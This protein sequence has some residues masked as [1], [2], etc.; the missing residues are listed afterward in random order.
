M[1]EKQPPKNKSR[2]HS[3][4]LPAQKYQ[5][6]N[7]NDTELRPWTIKLPEPPPLWS[8]DGYGLAPEEQYFQYTEDPPRLKQLSLSAYEQAN[9]KYDGK[10]VLYMQMKLFWKMLSDEQESYQEEIALIRRVQW[11]IRYG[12][13]FFLQGRPTW[14]T[15]WHYYY[16]NFYYPNTLR[17]RRVDYRD[18]D[19]ITELFEWYC[20]TCTEV[21]KELDEKGNAVPNE[22]GEY[23]MIDVGRRVCFGSIQPKR[24]RKG[25]TMKANSKM[26]QCTTL[27]REFHSV[28]QANTG[29]AAEDLY[30][31]HVLPA[32]KKLPI[33]LR[34][35]YDGALDSSAGIYFR[36]PGSIGH[37]N[38][39]DSW[40]VWNPSAKEGVNDRRKIAWLVDDEAAKV[41]TADVSK[42]WAIDKLTLAQ[43]TSIHG[44]SVHPSTVEEMSSSGIYYQTMWEHSNF[45]KRIRANGQTLSG[46]FRI[47]RKVDYGSDGFI[48][49][50]GYSVVGDPTEWQLNNPAHDSVY[51]ILKKGSA[52]YWDEYYADMIADSTKHSQYRIEIR[53]NP[54]RSA[55][56]WL[57]SVGDMGW[58]YIILDQRLAELRIKPVSIKGNFKRRGDIVD[59]HQDDNGRFVVSN[60][61]LG[62]QNQWTYGEDVW[63]EKKQSFVTAKRPLYPSRFVAGGDP[64]DYGNSN[65]TK[66]QEF[67]L[68]KGGGA[69]LH[70]ADP[71]ESHKN[72]KDWESLQ[73]VCYYENKPPSLEEYCEDMLAMCVFYGAMMNFESNKR[74]AIEYFIDMGYGG[75]LWHASNPDGTI[76]KDPGTYNTAGTKNDM[77]NA[78]RDFIEFRAHKCSIKEFLLQAKEM[79]HPQ[80]M[81][82]LDGFS[83]VGWSIYA[84]KNTYGMAVQR[85][86]TNGDFD[87]TLLYD[88]PSF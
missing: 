35:I 42:R 25:E 40:L 10:L 72:I 56:C 49:K 38:Y 76:K 31:D 84:A 87:L 66:K 55:D 58:S 12:Y 46:L 39:T 28:L 74:R 52:Q 82:R 16:L 44:Y 61:F 15:P 85:V 59:W 34:P 2:Y 24:R 50:A 30:Q 80:A 48:D 73:L 37:E 17:G 5:T 71:A 19:R 63:D 69:V 3:L 51:H 54:R 79:T 18:E 7:D 68:S 20:Y 81:S 13:W 32:W 14:I 43:G 27:N 67:H 57:G 8:I 29:D 45:Y 23:E 88:A 26:I 21:F 41:E 75:Y 78:V 36:P 70:C 47:F 22:N 62:Q 64:F 11:H 77:L 4:Y 83:A 65:P 53:K 1:Q 33:W 9:A 60:L 6:F 86:E